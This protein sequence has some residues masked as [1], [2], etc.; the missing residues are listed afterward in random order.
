MGPCSERAAGNERL[1]KGESE[2]ERIP[3]MPE[4]GTNNYVLTVPRQPHSWSFKEDV[5]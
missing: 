2:S 3:T 1:R 5:R 4:L